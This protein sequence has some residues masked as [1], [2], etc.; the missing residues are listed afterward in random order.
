MQFKDLKTTARPVKVLALFI[1]PFIMVCTITFIVALGLSIL[2]PL[3]FNDVTSSAALW[4][5]NIIL[6]IFFLAETG[7]WLSEK[8]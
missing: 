1:V 4:V 8:R 3:T 7:E 6:Y 5:L 2:T